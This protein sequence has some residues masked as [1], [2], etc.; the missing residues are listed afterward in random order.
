MQQE[1]ELTGFSGLSQPEAE[2]R[3]QRDGPNELPHPETSVFLQPAFRVIREPMILLLLAAGSIYFVLGD[4]VEAVILLSS[5][6]LILAIE[7]YQE[8]KSERALSALRDLSSPRALVIRDGQRHRIPG[9]ELVRDDIMVV[10]EGDRVAADAVLLWSDNLTIDESLLTGESV[11]VRKNPLITGNGVRRTTGTEPHIYSGTLVTSGQGVAHVTAT[12]VATEMGRIGS[13]LQSQAEQPTQLQRE[14]DRIVRVLAAVALTLCVIVIVGYSLTLGSLL[15][16]FLAGITLA[17]ALVP[18]EFPVVLTVFPAL[19]AW[20]I[21]RSQVLTRKVSAIEA[22]GSATLLAVDK[23]G[24]LTQNRMSVAV[25]AVPGSRH[26]VGEGPLPETFTRLVRIGMLASPAEPFDPMDRAIKHLSEMQQTGT[27]HHESLVKSYP[28]SDDLLAMA[29]VWAEP[30]RSAHRVAAKGAPEAIVDLCR[31]DDDQRRRLFAE[32]SE[33]AE[34]GLRVLAVAEAG[35]ATNS[36]LPDNLRSFAFAFVGLVALADPIRPT[37]PAAIAES[38]RAGMRV[39]ML[40]GDYPV[41]A[42]SIASQVGLQPLDRIL[43]GPEMDLL[44]DRELQLCVPY[45]SV[46]A[47]VRPEQKL[48]LVR[49]FQAHGEIVAMT[50]DG[51]NDAPAL[52]AANIGIAMGERGTDVARESADLVLLDDDFASIVRAV[53]LGRRIF[54]NLQK[55][56]GFLLAVHVPIAGL[57]LLPILLGWP[58]TLLPLHV[59]FLELIIDPACTLAFEA[60]PEEP[61]VM[62]RPPRPPGVALFNVRIIVRSLLQGLGVLLATMGVLAWTQFSDTPETDARALTFVTLVVAD[63]GL[64]LVNRSTS[65]SIL[66]SVRRRNRIMWLVLGAAIGLLAVVTITPVTRDLFQFG[67]LHPKNLMVPAMG[68]GLALVWMYTVRSLPW[69]NLR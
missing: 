64:I 54:D 38:Y 25:L 41:T 60:E 44:T 47:R 50:G 39:V 67:E 33:M 18:E 6:A 59:V 29:N 17:M 12:G 4:A 30:G 9:R 36:N 32:V 7:L 31:L 48:R 16:G 21:A 27:R 5:I 19:G 37:V 68:I 65:G 58:M 66:S 26:V 8:G 42:R 11:P 53:R 57:S 45:V 13:S 15:D 56:V 49:A 1:S 55:A 61:Q 24:T 28:L 10:A 43:S 63:L 62:S 34:A 14:I 20:R 51:V 23:T 22:L 35:I 3:L 69:L 2:A 40:T 52:K 46:F